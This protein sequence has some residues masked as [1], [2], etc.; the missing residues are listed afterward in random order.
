MGSSRA[1][2]RAKIRVVSI[3][4]AAMIQRGVF[5]PFFGAAAGSGFPRFGSSRLNNTDPGNSA[6]RR[7]LVAL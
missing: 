6:T 2:V 4:S 7:S 5:G 1:Q 3:I